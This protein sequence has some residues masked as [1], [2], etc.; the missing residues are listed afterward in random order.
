MNDS[1]LISTLLTIAVGCAGAQVVIMLIG[2]I[3]RISLAVQ[4]WRDDKRRAKYYA[5]EDKLSELKQLK[6]Q[7]FRD[8]QVINVYLIVKYGVK[9]LSELDPKDYDEVKAYLSDLLN[10]D[11]EHDLKKLKN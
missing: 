3:A 8:W 5:I 9:T 11:P 1:I 2:I 10:K 4:D 7:A 6:I